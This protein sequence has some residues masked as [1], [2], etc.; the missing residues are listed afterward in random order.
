MESNH[1][2]SRHLQVWSLHPG[3][4][5]IIW[6]ILNSATYLLYNLGSNDSVFKQI[7]F[8]GF[9][10]LNGTLERGCKNEENWKQFQK[11][12]CVKGYYKSS[13]YIVTFLWQ[14]FPNMASA[15]CRTVYR[16]RLSCQ[17]LE[18]QTFAKLRRSDNIYTDLID[19]F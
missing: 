6:T 17:T 12:E 11:S 3:P 5:R 7:Y 4:P 14:I 18:L 2:A 9:I 16:L 19:T 13:A 8:P 1:C 15:I 10:W